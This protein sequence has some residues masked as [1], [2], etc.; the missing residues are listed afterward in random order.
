MRSE[1]AISCDNLGKMYRIYDHPSKI[2]LESITRKPRHHERWVL[3]NISFEIG[4]GEIVGIIGANGS[5]KSTLLKIIA[6]TLSPTMGRASV[7]GKISAILELGTGFN[8][9]STGR[10]NIEMGCACLGMRPEEIKEKI[11]WIIDFSELRHVIDQPFKTYSSGMQAR[12]T[13]STAVS[14]DPD[15]FIVDEALAA[16][17]AYFV[18]KSLKRIREICNSG[19]TVLFVSHSDAIITE[20]CGRAIWLQE[21]DIK[22]IGQAEPVC[23]AYIESIWRLEGETTAAL[24]EE[25]TKAIVD[26][27]QYELNG[28][29]IKIT[30]IYTA[31]Q[32]GN[33]KHLF[34]TGEPMYVCIEWEG[35]CED[36]NVYASFRLDNEQGAVIS[37]FDGYEKKIFINEGKPFEGKGKMIYGIDSLDLGAGRYSISVSICKEMLP[38]GKEAILHYLEKALYFSVKRRGARGTRLIYE[39]PISLIRNE[40]CL[41]ER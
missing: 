36:Q 38:K 24:N 19:A 18:Q 35:K 7:N 17:D 31:D 40:I 29:N 6:G 32:N 4:K 5:G 16:G 26:S 25:R 8:P 22:A 13:F 14:V 33:M 15:I 23:K 27:S 39:P 11:E 21:G 37:A 41:T 1:V 2:F 28:D 34:T 3:K 9:A 12:L 10:Q 30:D 20:L